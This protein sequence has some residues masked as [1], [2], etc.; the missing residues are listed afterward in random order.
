MAADPDEPAE[1]EP[2]ENEAE[3]EETA[4]SEE[5]ADSE[6]AAE[7]EESADSEETE[8]SEESD[9]SEEPEES[10]EEGDTEPEA[11]EGEE[12]EEEAEE[13]SGEDEKASDE[14]DGEEEESEDEGEEEGEEE[15]EEEE[16]EE[17]DSESEDDEEEDEDGEEEEDEEGEEEEDEGEE[18]EGEE[19]EGDDEDEEEEEGEEDEEEEGEEDEEEEGEEDEEEEDDEAMVATS[20]DAGDGSNTLVMGDGD[21]HTL[22]FRLF[23]PFT[24]AMTEVP[25]R[26]TV[27]DQT[28]EDTTDD[29]WVEIETEEVPEKA[30]VEWGEADDPGSY[31]YSREV[32]LQ[33]EDVDDDEATKRRLHNLG[34]DEEGDE[35]QNLDAFREHYGVDSGEDSMLVAWFEDPEQ[36]QERGE[37]LEG[38]DEPEPPPQR[39]PDD[40]P[41]EE[42]GKITVTIRRHALG[43]GTWQVV[44]ADD[45]EVQDGVTSTP[46]YVAV[47]AQSQGDGRVLRVRW[48]DEDGTSHE[49]ATLDLD[50]LAGGEALEIDLPET[51]EDDEIV[52]GTGE[53][54]SWPEPPPYDETQEP[55]PI[56]GTPA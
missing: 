54:E 29:G 21:T 14:E 19:E 52:T 38:G 43:T 11:S 20:D 48:N 44:D 46:R 3:S 24:T 9:E 35:T 33:F 26:I 5:S 4:E 32:Y 18:E 45:S 10:E 12:E 7:S 42:D 30:A 51:D 34:Y 23:D 1:N 17:N 41:E 40:E 2:V 39:D 22:R 36:I 37:P 31:R 53:D 6:E 16:E 49:V 56:S 13:E 8:E 25:Y 47:T 55:Q 27:G 15:E 50:A 28:V